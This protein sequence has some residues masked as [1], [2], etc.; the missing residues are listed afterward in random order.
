MIEKCPVC[1]GKGVLPPNF[2][3]LSNVVSANAD[4]I[5]CRSCD[6]KGYIIISSNY[7]DVEYT[8]NLDDT[9][10]CGSCNK[11]DGLCYY[12]NPPK[13][14]CMLSGKFRNYDDTCEYSN[15]KLSNIPISGRVKLVIGR[16][17]HLS[18]LSQMME[19]ICNAHNPDEL[20]LIKVGP[21]NAGNIYDVYSIDIQN[22][23]WQY[24]G[25]TRMI[26]I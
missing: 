22:R 9:K 19:D 10:Y 3:Q 17:D 20:V 23:R 7:H 1:E 2:Y 14:K 15:I 8:S 11:T 4:P 21:F 25:D 18:E 24:I 12:T 13:V 6:G 5:T 26:D 16:V